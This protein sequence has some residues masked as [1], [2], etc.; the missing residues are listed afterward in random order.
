MRRKGFTLIELLVVVAIIAVLVAILL[1]AL[2]AAR[3]QAQTTICGSRLKQLGMSVQLYTHE[4]NEIYPPFFMTS[5]SLPSWQSCV[6]RM[7]GMVNE[8]QIREMFHC[9]KHMVDPSHWVYWCSYGGNCHLG[10]SGPYGR[11][12]A[13]DI[14]EPSRIML[15]VDT[16]I[17]NGWNCINVWAEPMNPGSLYEWLAWR[18]PTGQG[19][20]VLF[21]DQHV[22]NMQPDDYRDFQGYLVP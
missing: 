19:F 1:P 15:L 18:H 5:S 12:N 16:T 4:N 6:A 10:V 8:A 22:E 17:E 7:V 14:L 13:D 2:Q 21:C 9:P 11:R 20:N 3:E